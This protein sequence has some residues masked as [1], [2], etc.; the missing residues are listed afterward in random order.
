MDSKSLRL[1][2]LP[3]IPQIAVAT[4]YLD[5]AVS[6]HLAGN[7]ELADQRI[8]QADM[9]EIYKWTDSIWR[10]G[11]PHVRINRLTKMPPIV[12]KLI[13]AKPYMPSL[14]GKRN[15][16][17]RDG[18]HCR[19]CGVPVIRSEV[20]RAL[21][22]LFPEALR[23]TTDRRYPE[24][25]HAAFQALEAHYDHLLAHSRGGGCEPENM[26]ITC[27]PCNYGKDCWTLEALA[28]AD[29]RDRDPIRSSWDGLERILAAGQ[30]Q[31]SVNSPASIAAPLT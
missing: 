30:L 9:P 27:A 29:P 13:R 17:L 21:R 5:E 11:S 14:T 31:K 7:Q 15:L 16:F 19:Y 8:R 10:P 1:C 26:V 3:P 2:F 24:Q 6:A 20:R 4:Q 23:W 12:P 25:Q 28:L 18:Y 22:L